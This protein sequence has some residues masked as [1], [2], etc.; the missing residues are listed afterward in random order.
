M[1]A[2]D[3]LACAV[4]SILAV[5]DL[6]RR[7]LPNAAVAAYAALYF[8]HAWLAGESRAG[9]E[10]HVAAGIGALAFAAVL[11]RFGW[12][13]GGDAKLFAAVFL[14]TGPLHAS[15]VFFVI[16][17]SGLVLAL[18]QMA[19]GRLRSRANAGAALAW[20]APAR[21]VPYGVALAAGGIAALWLPHGQAHAVSLH[22]AAWLPSIHVRLT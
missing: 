16:S 18:A 5:S 13:G 9:L 19:C 2:I 12:L 14:W 1:D 10:A 21:G 15:A 17:L 4:L 3:A 11:F 20:L 6:R 22:Q 8:M 7:R